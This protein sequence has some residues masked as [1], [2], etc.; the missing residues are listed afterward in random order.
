MPKSVAVQ[1]RS[2]QRGPS[3]L[4]VDQA[5]D[6]QRYVPSVVSRLSM[7]LRVSAKAYFQKHYGVTLLDW[8]ILSF[9]VSNGPASPYDI[10]TMGTLDK[11]AVSRALKSLHDRGL[12]RIRD[13]PNSARR[14]TLVTLSKAGKELHD[15]MF[16]DILT[17]HERLVGELS[18]HEI[19]TFVK[20]I[21][22]LESRISEMDKESKLPLSGYNP[23]KST[24][25]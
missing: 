14:R 6:F 19:E 8:R 17:R 24:Q 5:I 16:D 13:V 15:R 20:T 21:E 12:T 3:P 7:K 23:T 4:E 1:K 25:E 10:W 18:R 9:L 11:A 22:Y 2:T